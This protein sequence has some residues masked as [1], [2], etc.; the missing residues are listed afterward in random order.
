MVVPR[1][2]VQDRV[3]QV[4]GEGFDLVVCAF[5]RGAARRCVINRPGSRRPPSTPRRPA[6]GDGWSA[7]ADGTGEL[8]GQKAAKYTIGSSTMGYTTLWLPATGPALPI[9]ETGSGTAGGTVTFTWNSA[10]SVNPPPA[11][12][13]DS[14]S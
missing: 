1:W 8:N 14:G 2:A 4:V 12:Q 7:T 5:D 9:E 3:W 6:P 11:N 13:V 10:L